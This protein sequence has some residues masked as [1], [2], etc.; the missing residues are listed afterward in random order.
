MRTGQDTRANG[1]RTKKKILDAAESLF[2]AR[3]FDS[4]SLRDITVGA[5]VTLALASY[6]FKTKDRL[7]EA[8]VA[9]RA[10][11]LCKLR[12]ERLASMGE[13]PGAGAILDAFMRP[14]FEQIESG[15][16]GW[17]AYVRILA[18]LGEDDRWL[19]LLGENFDDVA[20]EFL[21]ALAKTC[22][23][24]KREKLARR[25][26]MALNLM[27]AAVARHKRLDQL[28]RGAVRSDDLRQVYA[29]LLEFATAGV[30]AEA[31]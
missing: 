6:H 29:E 7:F 25:F 26:V 31:G 27:L 28:T 4:V 9:R 30:L 8:V 1:E 15:D 13:N 24:A 23:E 3:G 12:R 11:V 20:R 17:S 2:G 21:D 18:R 19:H 10:D 16:R 14:L 22:P 5:E